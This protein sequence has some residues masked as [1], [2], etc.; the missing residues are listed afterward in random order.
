MF[1]TWMNRQVI[2]VINIIDIFKLYEDELVL[3]LDI[4]FDSI[5][6]ENF[7]IVKVYIR[8]RTVNHSDNDL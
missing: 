3:P 8:Y 4:H 2:H 1:I 5:Y 6:S 7:I